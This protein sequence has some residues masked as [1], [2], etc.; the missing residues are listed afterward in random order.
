MLTTGLGGVEKSCVFIKYLDDLIGIKE[1]NFSDAVEPISLII[2]IIII[3]I[4]GR[5][6]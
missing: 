1:E 5:Y 6:L 2:I 3:I 4:P